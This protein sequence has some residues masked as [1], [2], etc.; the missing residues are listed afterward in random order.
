MFKKILVVASLMISLLPTQAADLPTYPF[1]HSS[2]NAYMHVA[3]DR[4]DI[5]FEISAYDA[6]PAVARALIDARSAELQAVMTEHG[7]GTNEIAI[8]DVR[9]EIRKAN[10]TDPKAEPIYD[11][12]C[13]VHIEVNDLK[14]WRPLMSTLLNMKNLTHFSTSFRITTR[15]QIEMD[16]SALAVKDAQRRAEAMARGLGKHVGAATAI[17]AGQL[18]NLSSAIGLQTSNS[19]T[20]AIQRNEQ[21]TR[22]LLM[23]VALK[24][25][26]SV[27]AIFKIK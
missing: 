17:S 2:G 9:R 7:G 8:R 6:D 25:E 20:E 1:I 18:K 27:D 24:F 11:I 23:I 26:Q 21:E 5:D 3:P 4:G 12:V 13:T 19:E 15:D 10:E 16:L 22:D 14:E